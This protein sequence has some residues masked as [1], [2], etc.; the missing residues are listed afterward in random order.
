MNSDPPA[1][2]LPQRLVQGGFSRRLIAIVWIFMAVVVCMLALTYYSIGLMSATRAYV[3]GEG[4]WSKAQ[5]EAVLALSRYATD[6]D[7][8][9]YQAYQAALAVSLGDRQARLEMEKPQSDAG[10]AGSGFLRGRNHPDDVAGMISLFHNFRGLAEID[11]ALAIWREA[12][13]HMER[14]MALGEQIHTAVRSGSMDP[15]ATRA[16]LLQLQGIN[17]QLTPLEDA[18]SF[19]L[20]DISRKTAQALQLALLVVGMVLLAVAYLLSRRLV[21]QN[22]NF[23]AALVDSRDQ[24][25]KLL[26]FAPL[27]IIIVR[28]TDESVVYANQRACQQFKV[29]EDGWAGLKPHAFYEREQDREQVMQALREHGSVRD[30]EVRLRDTQG[31]VFWVL[32]SSQRTL[33]AG[34][35]CLVTAINNIHERKLAQEALHH[36]AFHDELT[37]LPN[38]AMFMDALSRSLSRVERRSGRLSLL[39]IDL[40]HFKEVNDRHG[41]TVGDLLL[42]AVA[43]RIRVCVREGDLV[44]RLG[45][46]EFVILVEDGDT[47]H[48]VTHIAQKLQKTLQPMHQL[49]GHQL[50]MTASMGISSYPQDGEELTDL[51][52]NADDAMYRAKEAGRNNFQFSDSLPMDSRPPDSA[53]P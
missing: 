51:L 22:E 38:R 37:G 29:P 12:D 49:G 24:L 18:F 10:Q 36:R 21:R 26:Q 32:I 25:R 41:H 52:R 44:A 5:K 48:E 3:G 8:R 23:Q 6:R 35:P 47:H 27:P 39:F 11:K 2:P 53:L 17:Q 19:T 1:E 50:L 15:A 31:T 34:Q 30:W 16:Y 7:P 4:L 9:D 46:D 14:L 13:G 28:L 42:Q 43:M 45:G 33:Y 20:G 40:D